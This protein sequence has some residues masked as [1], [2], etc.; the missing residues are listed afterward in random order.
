MGLIAMRERDLQRIEVL[1][2]VA[3]GRMTMVSAAHVLDVSTRQVHRLLQAYDRD[4]PSGLVSKKRSV[5]DAYRDTVTHP[6]DNRSISMIA[7][8]SRLPFPCF[9]NSAN[10]LA[11]SAPSGVEAPVASAASW[12]RRKSFSIRAAAKPGL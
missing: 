4:G 9:S 8:K 11:A 12:D 2:K 10:S 6:S 1:S 5:L 7:E 3:A